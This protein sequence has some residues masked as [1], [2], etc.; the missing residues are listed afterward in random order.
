MGQQPVTVFIVE[1][2][3]DIAE[4]VKDNLRREGFRVA[5]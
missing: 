1:D 2:D 5:I 4:I 3:P